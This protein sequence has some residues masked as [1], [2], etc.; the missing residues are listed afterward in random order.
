MKNL[1]IKMLQILLK[2]FFIFPIRKNRVFFS[3]YSGKSYSCNPKYICEYLMS[4]CGD[5]LDIIWAF[6][7]PDAFADIDPRIRRVKFKS[8]TYLYYLLTSR[9][10]VDN[11]ESW[12]ILPRRR[13]QY[14]INTWHGGG[15]YKGVGLRRRDTDSAL[16]KNMLNKHKRVDLYLSSSSAFT[17][18]TLRESFGYCGEVLECGM[19]RNDILK[20]AGAADA[21]A[22]RERLGVGDDDRL[23]L[24][25]PTFRR[26]LSFQYSLD[27]ERVLSALT[28]RFG[29]NWKFLFRAH[30][31]LP[32]SGGAAESVLDVSD[33]PDMQELLLVSDVLITD[34]SSSIWDFSLTGKAGFLFMPDLDDY[35]SERDFYT[36]VDTWPYKHAVDMDSLETIIHEYDENENR[37]RIRSHHELLGNCESGCASKLTGDRIAELCG[38]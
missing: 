30:Y 29:G 1:L 5:K 22:I 12:S 32:K 36:P 31:Y 13:G 16:D 2:V 3:A 33:Y 21:R 38:K 23:V 37:E 4:T 25:A 6:T 27:H 14:V 28:E 17:E 15:A 20:N 8:V 24:F 18:M 7:D 26:D 19:P 10:V 35:G 34:Y 9:V 11:V